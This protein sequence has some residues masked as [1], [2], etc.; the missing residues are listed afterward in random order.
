MFP[1]RFVFCPPVGH[2]S[3]ITRLLDCRFLCA[4]INVRTATV[5]CPCW[6]SWPIPAVGEVFSDSLPYCGSTFVPHYGRLDKTE[7]LLTKLM[8][9]RQKVSSQQSCNVLPSHRHPEHT[10]TFLPEWLYNCLRQD[11]Y[12]QIE[13]AVTDHSDA[14]SP[15]FQE[16]FFWNLNPYVILCG[17][18]GSKHQLAN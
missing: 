1:A 3:S 6:Y 17:W 8:V 13:P 14:R 9:T 18:F 2:T 16:H 7:M 10:F 12:S 15:F 11:D 5:V 4:Q